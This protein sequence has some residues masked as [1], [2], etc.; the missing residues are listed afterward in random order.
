MPRSGGDATLAERS[1][2]VLLLADVG[3]ASVAL[4]ARLRTVRPP[5]CKARQVRAAVQ[6]RH[7]MAAIDDASSP[8]GQT[9]PDP[10]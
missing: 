7:A 8:G 2:M 1:T 4:A 3:A 10:R 6:R 5:T 9:L